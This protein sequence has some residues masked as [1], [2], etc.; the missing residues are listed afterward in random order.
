MGKPSLR[1]R[2]VSESGESLYTAH[3]RTDITV[4]PNDLNLGRTG[5]CSEKYDLGV[6]V[7]GVS[8]RT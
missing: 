6:Y 1:E 2:R 7:S 5:A 3:Q 4:Q 8:L